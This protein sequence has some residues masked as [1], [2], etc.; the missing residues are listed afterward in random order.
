MRRVAVGNG[1]EDDIGVLSHRAGGLRNTRTVGCAFGGS[2]L[3]MHHK[4][5]TGS[6]Q[7]GRHGPAHVAEPDEPECAYGVDSSVL[8]GHA[9]LACS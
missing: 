3:V 9:S 2:R 6:G 8:F 7:I 5:N 4:V 1:E